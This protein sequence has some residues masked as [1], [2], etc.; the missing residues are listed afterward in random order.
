VYNSHGLVPCTV[1][2]C[3]ASV[4][5]VLQAFSSPFSLQLT[6]KVVVHQ[7]IDL[8]SLHTLIGQISTKISKHSGQT[9]L[10]AGSA[11]YFDP[12]LSTLDYCK[13][14]SKSQRQPKYV[15]F[16]L[17][18]IWSQTI[19]KVSRTTLCN[20]RRRRCRVNSKVKL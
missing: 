3:V 2:V 16:F 15:T 20:D 13:F 18:A 9:L 4:N 6:R 8:K 14:H 12:I 19:N 1:S 11:L 7:N 17:S 5:D 10:V